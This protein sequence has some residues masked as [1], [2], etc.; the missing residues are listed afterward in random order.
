MKINNQIFEARKR[1]IHEQGEFLEAMDHYKTGE[2]LENPSE[3]RKSILDYNKEVLSK[4]EC[5]TERAQELREMKAETVEIF[6]RIKDD[7]SEESITWKEFTE[8]CRKV[9]EMNKFV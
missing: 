5:R 4:N 6:S 3:I 2:R 8:V 9:H 1:A 7:D